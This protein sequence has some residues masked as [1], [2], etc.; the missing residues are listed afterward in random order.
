MKKVLLIIAS[1]GFQQVEYGDT[2]AELEA[3]GFTVVT[4]GDKVGKAVGKDGVT[5]ANIVVALEDV[6]I[7][8]YDGLYFIGGPGALPHLDNEEAYKLLRAWKEAG[9]PYGAICISTRVLA[10]AGVTKGAAA[11]GWNGDGELPAILQEYGALHVDKAAHTD[12]LITTGRDPAAAREFGRAIVKQ[13][14]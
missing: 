8:D 1:V 10:K 5:R 14:K 11:T 13:F 2:K 9:K 6:N 7:D 4:G 3:A 12:G